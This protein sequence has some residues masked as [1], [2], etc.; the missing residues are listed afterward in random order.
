M[1][2]HGEGLSARER[3]IAWDSRRG[4]RKGSRDGEPSGRTLGPRRSPGAPPARPAWRGWCAMR[5]GPTV[6]GREERREESGDF[7]GGG[8]RGVA[9]GFGAHL[10]RGREVAR[11]R[12]VLAPEMGVDA[13]AF[14]P[15]GVDAVSVGGAAVLGETSSSVFG[16]TSSSQ[17]RVPAVFGGESA[18]QGAASSEA[19]ASSGVSARGVGS[20]LSTR[21]VRGALRVTESLAGGGTSEVED[22]WEEGSA[23]PDNRNF[24]RWAARD[25]AVRGT[26]RLGEP[27]AFMANASSPA[28][29][30]DSAAGRGGGAKWAEWMVLSVAARR[31]AR[32]SRPSE[33]R[34][35]SSK[36]AWWKRRMKGSLAFSPRVALKLPGMVPLSIRLVLTLIF[37]AGASRVAHGSM[38]AP[39]AMA[40]TRN[41]AFTTTGESPP[42][43][44]PPRPSAGATNLLCVAA[45][46]ASPEARV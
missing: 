36:D 8:W 6:A 26:E 27:G 21:S 9:D 22:S 38:H 7:A 41:D 2:A 39:T 29:K 4:E 23:A 13:S 34:I 12:G 43:G 30:N 16:G 33:L 28:F 20:K 25:S 40:L 15:E 11:L 18:S 10:L 37:D 5:A 35:Q 45:E 1:S 42:A 17:A 3:R 24:H 31:N 32:G 14:A 44:V 46:E 19:E